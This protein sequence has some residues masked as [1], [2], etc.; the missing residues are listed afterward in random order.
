MRHT[1]AL[2]SERREAGRVRVGARWTGVR[3]L[4]GALSGRVRGPRE[5]R[6]PRATSGP[7]LSRLWNVIKRW[8]WLFHSTAPMLD[9]ASPTVQNW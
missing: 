8:L 3:H 4:P 1:A 5:T 7:P 6:M 9:L 2:A